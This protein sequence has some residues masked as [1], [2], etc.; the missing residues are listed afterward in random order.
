MPWRDPSGFLTAL[1]EFFCSPGVQAAIAAGVL[2]TLTTA[3]R[4]DNKIL[5]KAN[6]IECALCVAVTWCGAK[7]L[8]AIGL[9][10]DW[11]MVIGLVVG[12][13]GTKWIEKMA[14]LWAERK[15]DKL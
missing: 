4:G 13:F 1:I 12:F 6:F 5:C 15:I 8:N 2:S 10:Q 11:A 7:S 3:K 9:S 14:T